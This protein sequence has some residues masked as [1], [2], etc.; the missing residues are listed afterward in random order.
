MGVETPGL[1]SV[2]PIGVI[3]HYNLLEA[4]P[5][6]GPGDLFRARDTIR[7]RTVIIRRLPAAQAD[8]P[9]R[10][11]IE[12]SAQALSALSHPNAIR[13]FDSGDDAG[14]LYLVF[15]HLQGSTLRQE[16]GGRQ[17]NVRRSLELAIQI[18]DAVAEA[19]AAGYLH[20]G[21]SAESVVITAK[22][23]AKIPAHPLACRE[24]FIAGADAPSLVDYPSPEEASGGTPDERSDVFSVGALLYEMLT[25]RRPS[26]KGAARPSATNTHVPRELDDV[27]L[28]AV[29]PNPGRRF[30]NAA[31]LVAS[32]RGVLAVHDARGAADDEFADGSTPSRARYW[33]MGG[34]VVAVAA[35]WWL[36]RR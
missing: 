20:G 28:Q 23:H 7:G 36:T 30:A 18:A 4:L 19:H 1:T 33:M 24:G 21:L 10:R 11:A 15:E 6:A 16:L 31:E 22:G 9:A 12:A 2:E 27:V 3:A 5:A 29:S 14:R 25:A 17:M 13:L 26:L 34:L 35:V 32:L 8:D